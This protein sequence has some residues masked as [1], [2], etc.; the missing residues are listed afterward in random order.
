MIN[1]V[2]SILPTC[3]EFSTA[4]KA[5]I[6]SGALPAFATICGFVIT[7]IV[8]NNNVK[9]RRADYIS[10]L[11]DRLHNDPLIKDTVYIFQYDE[12]WYKKEF[13]FNR[14]L[15]LKVDTTLSYLSYICYLQEKKIIR[16]KEFNLFKSMINHAASNKS[17]LRYFY[18]LR[19]Y[20]KVYS[21]KVTTKAKHS[22]KRTNKKFTESFTF[23]YLFDYI[24]KHKYIDMEKFSKA[25]L[26]D[27]I[28]YQILKR[29]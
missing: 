22:S 26:T 9:T 24:K 25:D 21:S 23:K 1:I 27:E 6:I 17:T 4:D 29:T 16:K 2:Q 19:H 11:L 8:W 10:D 7:V 15:E 3:I 12:N 20:S 5:T 13:Y 28:Y 14:D 18:N